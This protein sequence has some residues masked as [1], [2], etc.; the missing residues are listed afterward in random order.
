MVLIMD[1]CGGCDVRFVVIMIRKRDHQKLAPKSPE[2]LVLICEEG[3]EIN[4]YQELEAVAC[5]LNAVELVAVPSMCFVW[6]RRK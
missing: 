1:P 3:R 6:V 4:C 2:L 5:S